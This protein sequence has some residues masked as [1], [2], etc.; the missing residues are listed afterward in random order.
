MA[1]DKPR[2][3]RLT[4]ILIQLQSKKL[5]GNIE[6]LQLEDLQGVAGLKALRVEVIYQ[7]D[8][9]GNTSITLDEL[10]AQIES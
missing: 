7:K 4:S 6:Y 2:L 10:L 3:L 1:E 9:D 5:L 8:F